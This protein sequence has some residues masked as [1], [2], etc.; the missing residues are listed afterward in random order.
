MKL[1]L[2]KLSALLVLPRAGLP[3]F[4]AVREWGGIDLD[5]KVLNT[6]VLLERAKTLDSKIVLIMLTDFFRKSTIATGLSGG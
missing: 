4:D 5:G 1:H 6:S 3:Q 2:A